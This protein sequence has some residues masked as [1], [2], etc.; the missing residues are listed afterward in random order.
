MPHLLKDHPFKSLLGFAGGHG[1]VH[2]LP[3]PG[4]PGGE[5]GAA[6]QEPV[7][8]NQVPAPLS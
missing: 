5:R 6:E 1:A 4:D 7:D 8:Q 2:G 3:G